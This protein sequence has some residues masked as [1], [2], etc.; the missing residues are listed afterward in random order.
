MMALPITVSPVFALPA[1]FC[2]GDALSSARAC[3]RFGCARRQRHQREVAVAGITF[4]VLALG[5]PGN[6]RNPQSNAPPRQVRVQAQFSF[7]VV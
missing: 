1:L 3:A 7:T 6:Q 4:G 5:W 2:G